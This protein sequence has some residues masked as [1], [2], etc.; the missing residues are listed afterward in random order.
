MLVCGVALFYVSFVEYCLYLI[1][2]R[3]KS[4]LDH[5]GSELFFKLLSSI[6]LLLIGFMAKT[7]SSKGWL[8]VKKYWI[9]FLVVGGFSLLYTIFNYFSK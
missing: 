8:P 4:K 9:Y 3:R 1:H 6:G 2:C 7:S 5:M